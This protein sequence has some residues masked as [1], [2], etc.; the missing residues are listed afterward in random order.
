MAIVD[1]ITDDDLKLVADACNVWLGNL[2]SPE[3][4][5]RFLTGEQS[6]AVQKLIDVVREH[7]ERHCGN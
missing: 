4:Y 7:G 2:C 6:V 5:R 3:G 1:H